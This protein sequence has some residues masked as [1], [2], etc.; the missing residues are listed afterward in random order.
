VK[1]GF[2]Q[3]HL[4]LWLLEYVGL[5]SLTAAEMGVTSLEGSAV[6][7]SEKLRPCMKVIPMG[8]TWALHFVQAT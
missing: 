2:Y 1:H 6:A 3:H 4:P 8:W 7:A 5:S